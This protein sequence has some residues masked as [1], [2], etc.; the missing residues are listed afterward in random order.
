MATNAELS[1]SLLIK[2]T[3]SATRELSKL[4]E[5]VKKS[6]RATS[7]FADDVDWAK[8]SLAGFL[9]HIKGASKNLTWLH[10]DFKTAKKSASNFGKEAGKS[11]SQL[12]Q[13]SDK[14]KGRLAALE[15]QLRKNIKASKDLNS[16]MGASGSASS[17][18]SA[19]SN[20]KVGG[21]PFKKSLAG[22]G[23][24]AKGVAG[25]AGAPLLL[26]DAVVAAG[27]KT[28]AV[29]SQFEALEARIN[30]V[31]A[32]SEKSKEIFHNLKEM[33]EETP[34]NIDQTTNSFLALYNNGL[35]PTKE[36]MTAYGDIASAMGM[37]LQDVANNVINAT[38]DN[39]KT[40]ADAFANLGINAKETKDGLAL[41]Y[42]GVTTNIKDN[43]ESIQG[44]FNQLAQNNF[45][46][47]M[48]EQMGT[49]GGEVAR[50]KSEW[51]ELF[52]N[53]GSG[54][55]GDAIKSAFSVGSD[56]LDT[57]NDSLASGQLGKYFDAYIG[58]LKAG[59]S[60]LYQYTMGDELEAALNGASSFFSKAY[61][62]WGGDAKEGLKKLGVNYLLIP[63]S[64]SSAL[65]MARKEFDHWMNYFDTATDYTFTSIKNDLSSASE[66]LML[67]FKNS[68]GALNPWSDSF[69]YEE[70]K[71]KVAQ[72]KVQRDEELKN[73]RG[74]KSEKLDEFDS[75][76][77]E[78]RIKKS[79]D[80]ALKQR[81][82]VTEELYKKLDE[83]QKLGEAYDKKGEN[84]DKAKNNT[85]IG[86]KPAKGPKASSGLT[87]AGAKND[88]QTIVSAL[89]PKS[90][91]T[92]AQK[93]AEET[94]KLLTQSC[95]RQRGIV[96]SS[97]NQQT[98][99]QTDLIKKRHEKIIQLERQKNAQLASEASGFMSQLQNLGD[100]LN[101]DLT[102]PENVE[103]SVQAMVEVYESGK[104]IIDELF[105]G[106]GEEE[107]PE[108]T[109]EQDSSVIEAQNEEKLAAT[110]ALA[111][112]Q[113]QIEVDQTKQKNKAM[114]DIER[115]Q[116]SQRLNQ[117]SDFFGGVASVAAA[118]GG[119]QSKAAK[120][121]AIA[122][123]TIKTYESATNAYASL[124]GIPY[125]G[126][127][128]G[129]AAAAAAVA[130]GMANV[131]AIKS[132]NYS[133]AY[134]HGG[135][136]PAGKIGLVGE[137]GPELI[138][139]PVNVTSRRTTAGLNTSN[140]AAEQTPQNIDKS[141]KFNY[142]IN[143]NDSEGV[144]QVMKRERAKIM[145]DVR[146]AMES[147]EWD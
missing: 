6:A 1:L 57:F 85:E 114:A 25:A 8:K 83:A 111:E 20:K 91:N 13:S 47:A 115:E 87:S 126:P 103:A 104:N 55:V 73:L 94:E 88:V 74:N 29:T 145:Q 33:A 49:M 27:Q 80:E 96:E 24:F 130:A 66:S 99:I 144:A 22:I 143:A 122:Q 100:S 105:L 9:S 78:E 68:I 61:E 98:Q 43:A 58:P 38:S 12:E 129:I 28:I 41:T 120:A 48:A 39:A 5:Q 46:G 52:L 26:A 71:K 97:E 70:E 90:D 123:T 18:V 23:S 30:V 121:A 84:Y 40:Q 32:S 53:I 101:G 128:L 108:Q 113:A 137:Y 69:D 31:A 89:D 64:I 75:S 132:T 110:Q 42:N 76:T 16:S 59:F 14:A 146:Y 118:F 136:I 2:E 117:A 95:E 93:N 133:G 109:D 82:K 147:G 79:W 51:D 21:S 77:F 10:Q 134:D 15:D 135:L 54:G 60:G 3:T 125:V 45:A 56:A 81:E 67:E 124:A 19:A 116:Q 36:A 17:S 44:Y 131:Q 138:A 142:V 86:L 11:F 50:F 92:S 112:E 139:G 140:S 72:N 65:G 127:A 106:T 107:D 62:K 35:I 119:K 4:E 37:S 102:N 141:V 34:H 7:D 63:Q